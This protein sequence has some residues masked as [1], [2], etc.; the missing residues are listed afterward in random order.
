MT[1]S[2]I[3]FIK[4]EAQAFEVNESFYLRVFGGRTHLMTV[5]ASD[6][7]G[8]T[9]YSAVIGRR[10]WKPDAVLTVVD[11]GFGED[12]SEAEYGCECE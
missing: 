1:S 11:E 12:G 2:E 8:V 3:N 9:A 5:E 6:H 7:T 4:I 10:N